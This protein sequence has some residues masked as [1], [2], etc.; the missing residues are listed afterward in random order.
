[1]AMAQSFG[2]NHSAETNKDY[3]YH[4]GEERSVFNKT[5]IEISWEKMFPLSL[6]QAYYISQN[7]LAEKND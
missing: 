2:V 3:A 1:M 4:M 6:E 7:F 5:A